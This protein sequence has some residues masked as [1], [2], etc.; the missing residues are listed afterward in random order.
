MWL[1]KSL[2]IRIQDPIS[3]KGMLS[4][5]LFDRPII[6]AGNP[7]DGPDFFSGGEPLG[8]TRSLIP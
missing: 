5:S 6:L 2:H 4:A 3:P 7:A 8:R 1:P